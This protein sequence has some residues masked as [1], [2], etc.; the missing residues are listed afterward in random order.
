MQLGLMGVVSMHGTSCWC[1]TPARSAMWS[2]NNR[3]PKDWLLRHQYSENHWCHAMRQNIY[4]SLWREPGQ[5]NTAQT[6]LTLK[7]MQEQLVVSKAT[8]RSSRQTADIWPLS[9]C[10]CQ[11]AAG[12]RS[13]VHTLVT[14]VS[15]WWNWRYTDCVGAI[16]SLLYSHSVAPC[17]SV[18]RPVW[19]S[20]VTAVQAT[21]LYI[22]AR[23]NLA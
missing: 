3:G 15:R 5:D 12:R 10:Q 16:R 18:C 13:P 8:V 2:T 14:V 7:T 20:Y 23:L 21:F 22:T 1:I 6:K 17:L 4:Q 19:S 11:H 9:G